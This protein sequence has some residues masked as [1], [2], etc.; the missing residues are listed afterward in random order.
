MKLHEE[1]ITILNILDLPKHQFVVVGSG[2]LMMRD[3]RKAGDLD[4][5]CTTELWF[6]TLWEDESDRWGVYVPNG[7]NPEERC[8]PP[9][10]YRTVN[11]I[12][13]NMFFSWRQREQ[14]NLNVSDAIA[15]AETI[16]EFP[17]QTLKDLMDWKSTVMRDKDIADLELIEK[18]LMIEESGVV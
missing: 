4:I 11:G 9:F 17:C 13:V 15:A 6:D 5:F 3:L 8:D 12:E 14:G 16:N 1:L 2:I 10:L 7:Y 18:Q